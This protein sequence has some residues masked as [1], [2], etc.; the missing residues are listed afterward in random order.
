MF[1]RWLQYLALVLI[2]ALLSTSQCY[3][4]CPVCTAPS[5]HPPGCHHQPEKGNDFGKACP[6]QISDFFTPEA[7]LDLAKLAYLDS[8][9]I[10][11]LLLMPQV[12]VVEIQP[13]AEILQR[14][15]HQV[16]PGTSVLALL[17]T[18]RV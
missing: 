3:A 5:S 2:A 4:A 12:Y 18:F 10:A 16:A 8:A 11:G 7:G 9:A 13:T 1:R 14:L 15:E 6:H 17:S